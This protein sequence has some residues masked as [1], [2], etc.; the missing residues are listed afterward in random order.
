[1]ELRISVALKQRFFPAL[2][3]TN[4]GLLI[5]FGVSRPCR[6]GPYAENPVG[7]LFMGAIGGFGI[8]GRCRSGRGAFPLPTVR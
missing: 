4:N 2:R 1:V 3:M 5:A 8:P 6:P 7:R